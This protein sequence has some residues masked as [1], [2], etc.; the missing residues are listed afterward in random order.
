MN[1]RAAKLVV[2][3]VTATEC[4]IADPKDMGMMDIAGYD[5]AVPQ[6]V[7]DFIRD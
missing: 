1:K 5:S 6:I 7:A 2:L 3:G 4:S